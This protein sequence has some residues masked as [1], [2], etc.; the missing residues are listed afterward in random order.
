MRVP[1]NRGKGRESAEAVPTAR[2][3]P[4]IGA[5]FH[6]GMLP[7]GHASPSG[8]MGLGKHTG[9]D[10]ADTVSSAVKAAAASLCCA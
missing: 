10:V 2:C 6:W 3:I 9:R 4:P 1:K 8:V 7:L 5:C